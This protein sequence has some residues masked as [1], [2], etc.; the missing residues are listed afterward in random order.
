MLVKYAKDKM[1][2]DSN[3]SSESLG[4]Y[5]YTMATLTEAL[6]PDILAEIKMFRAFEF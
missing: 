6:P 5:S 2:H 1:T 3:L 4:D